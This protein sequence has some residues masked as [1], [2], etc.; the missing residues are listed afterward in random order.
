MVSLNKIMIMGNLGGDP[1]M[2]YTPQGIPVTSFSVAVNRYY[3]DSSGERQSETQWFRISTWR[4]LA[5]NCNQYLGK[6]RRVYVEGSFRSRAWQAED[7]QTRYSNEINANQVIFL[8]RAG[9][10]GTQPNEGAFGEESLEPEDL[11]FES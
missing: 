3:K 6:G 8:D 9:E 4:Q 7:G 10:T 1:E 2:R 5:E 11:P